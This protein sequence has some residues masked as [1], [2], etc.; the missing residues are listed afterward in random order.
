[1]MCIPVTCA[2]FPCCGI[3]FEMQRGVGL[4]LWTSSESPHLGRVHGSGRSVRFTVGTDD[5]PRPR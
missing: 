4:W 1:M 2:S 3:R 5:R